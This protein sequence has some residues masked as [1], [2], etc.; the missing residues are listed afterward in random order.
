[1][2]SLNDD[3]EDG[4]GNITELIEILADDKAIAINVG[5]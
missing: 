1:M 2:I 3:V 5:D 4:D